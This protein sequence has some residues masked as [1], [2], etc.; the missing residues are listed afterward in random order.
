VSDDLLPAPKPRVFI[1][2]SSEVLLTA[3][4]LQSEIERLVDCEATCWDQDLFQISTYALETLSAAT[5]HYDFAIL[6]ATPDDTTSRRGITAPTARDN[7]IFELGLFIGAIGRDRTFLV[8]DRSD[9]HMQL[10]SD[11]AGLTFGAFKSRQ[12]GNTRAALNDPVL[13]ISKTIREKGRRAA[14]DQPATPADRNVMALETELQ[15]ICNAARA[16]GWKVK[17][18]SSTTLRLQDRRGQKHTLSLTQPNAS[19]A[20]L[21]EFVKQLRAAGLRVNRSV[22]QPVS[23]SVH[24]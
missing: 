2:S 6:V 14:A 16:Q 17:T 9:P 12:D 15:M 5:H 13:G 10:P 22:R 20:Q 18:L 7:V 1:G 4:Y 8:V 21:R 19:R 3:R 23:E 24:S 11:I